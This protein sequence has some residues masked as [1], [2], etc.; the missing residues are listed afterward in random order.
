VDAVYSSALR[1]SGLLHAWSQD[2][3]D[4][5]HRL[6]YSAYLIQ[7]I[8]LQPTYDAYFTVNPTDSRALCFFKLTGLYWLSLLVINA[9]SM[10]LHV[11]VEAPANNLRNH[12]VHLFSLAAALISRVGAMAARARPVP[13]E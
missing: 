9:A 13:A 6:S 2:A 12:A 8:F 10:L 5:A 11:L 3:F 7:F 4:C 1:L